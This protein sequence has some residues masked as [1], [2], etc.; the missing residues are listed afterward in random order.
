MPGAAKEW[1]HFPFCGSKC[2]LIDL[3]RWLGESYAVADDSEEESAEEE[4]G[5]NEPP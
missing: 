2:Q 5:E 1:P 4:D 3:S